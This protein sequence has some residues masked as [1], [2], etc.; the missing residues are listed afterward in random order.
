MDVGGDGAEVIAVTAFGQIDGNNPFETITGGAPEEKLRL[1]VFVHLE[2]VEKFLNV[3]QVVE[4]E[5]QQATVLDEFLFLPDGEGA[6]KGAV[7]E[8]R[9]FE[10]AGTSDI[11]YLPEILGSVAGIAADDVVVGVADGNLLVRDGVGHGSLEKGEVGLLDEGSPEEKPG[12]F[13]L[14]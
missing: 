2:L 3:Q 1:K 13:L 4:V 5:A 11:A 12:G 10:L 6:G 9:C 8:L 7:I 14:A